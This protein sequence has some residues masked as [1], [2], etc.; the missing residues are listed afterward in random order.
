MAEHEALAY[1]IFIRKKTPR[2]GCV[3]DSYERRILVVPIGEGTSTEERNSERPHIVRA[4][5]V[6][7]RMRITPRLWQGHSLDRNVRAAVIVCQRNYGSHRRTFNSRHNADAIEYLLPE[8]QDGRI[9]RILLRAQIHSHGQHAV[10]TKSRIDLQQ[11]IET[12]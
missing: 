6:I 10:G 4:D 9:L 5:G 11:A 7:V 1:R 12:F 8:I 3:N 2:Y